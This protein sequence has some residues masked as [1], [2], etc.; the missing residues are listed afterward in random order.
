MQNRNFDNTSTK[1]LENGME[2]SPAVHYFTQKLDFVSNI[3]SETVEIPDDYPLHG[4][5]RVIKLLEKYIEKIDKCTDVKVK[6]CMK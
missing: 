2:T 3:L 6:N 5:N 4:D 1:L